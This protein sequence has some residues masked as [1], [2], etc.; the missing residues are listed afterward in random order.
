LAISNIEQVVLKKCC[1][2]DYFLSDLLLCNVEENYFKSSNRIIYDIIIRFYN[3]HRQHPTLAEVQALLTDCKDQKQK[4]NCI[5]AFTEISNIQLEE[6]WSDEFVIDEFL[7]SKKTQILN[8]ML[9]ETAGSVNKKKND[10]VAESVSKKLQSFYQINR[11]VSAGESIGKS[12]VERLKRYEER[13]K[14]DYKSNAVRTGFT[15]ID[16]ATGGMQGGELWVFAA[17]AKAGKSQLLLNIG[18]N[19]YEMGRNVIYLSAE[20]YYESVNMRFDSRNAKVPYSKIKKGKLEQED[21]DKLNKWGQTCFNKQNYWHT[22]YE[23]GFNTA[24]VKKKIVEAELEYKQKPDLVIVDYLG[25]IR[26]IEKMPNKH[27]MLGQ[28]SR[29]LRKIASDFRVPVITAQQLNREGQ[30]MSREATSEQIG[31]TGLAL[32]VGGSLEILSDC[33]YFIP[34][35]VKDFLERKNSPVYT[36]ELSAEVVRDSDIFS[37]EIDVYKD[38][39]FMKEKETVCGF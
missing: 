13:C 24:Y 9:L 31:K 37:C 38:I 30:K 21:F 22:Y 3:Q 19:A 6:G 8:E 12:V 7:D 32:N 36:I 39:M 25:I 2:D 4:E 33:D 23:S 11:A 28:V 27:E 16:E 29:E 5:L 15:T 35:R 26:P 18:C 17:G 34:F 20:L 1:L 14:P 10:E